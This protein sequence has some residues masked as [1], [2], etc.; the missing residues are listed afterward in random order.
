M[1]RKSSN[2]GVKWWMRRGV[3]VFISALIGT[4]GLIAC[5]SNP[6]PVVPTGTAVAQV[7]QTPGSTPNCELPTAQIRSNVPS[8][9][10]AGQQVALV[11]ESRGTNL[12]YSWSVSAGTLSDSNSDAV[13]YTLPPVDGMVVITLRVDSSCG[14]A[15]DELSLNVVTPTHTPT[16]TSTF[17]PTPTQTPT[18]AVT[19]RP[20]PTPSPR[21]IL[22]RLAEPK[23]NTCVGVDQPVDF[24][25]Q[26]YR[27]LNTIND[28]KGAEYFALNFWSSRTEKHSVNWIKDTHY[29]ID[30]SKPVT[31]FTQEVDCSEGKG[32][33]WSVDVVV[34]N[35]PRG[36][37]WMPESFR[38]ITSS[39]VRS[40]CVRGRIN[41]IPPQDTPEP[42]PPP[43]PPV[44]PP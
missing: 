31:V 15:E 19:P 38:I 40:L 14:S 25:W 30:L 39:P 4:G 24:Q 12:T 35:V 29:L 32:C 23:N 21:P 44:C 9:G 27:S 37:G 2:N 10:L 17:T 41:P 1:S 8:Q 3:V 42:P 36:G 22:L 43:C 18:R 33:L 6:A 5:N 7:V 11:A 26:F 16:A 34:A 20:T 13:I 28:E